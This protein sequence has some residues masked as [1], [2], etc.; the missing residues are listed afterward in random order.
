MRTSEA[1]MPTSGALSWRSPGGILALG[2]RL[3]AGVVFVYASLDKM[4]HPDAFAQLVY[5]Y[6]LLP[7][8]L[9]HP[10]AVLLPPLEATVG[11]ALILG[12]AR[13]GAALIAAA[14]TVVFIGA[15]LSAMVR[16]LDISCGCFSTEASSGHGVGTG[17]LIRDLALLVVC[18]VPLLT[19]HP[20]WGLGDLLR[21]DAGSSARV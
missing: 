16:G 18:V 11:I 13:R 15:I 12:V 7:L 3:V 21:R 9:L 6:R 4:L 1:A 14:L 10:F 19:A 20:G 5:N 17:L 8:P 2:C